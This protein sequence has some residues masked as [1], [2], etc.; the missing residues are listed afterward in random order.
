MDHRFRYAGILALALLVTG[1]FPAQADAVCGPGRHLA[2]HVFNCLRGDTS[3]QAYQ[4]SNPAA[5]VA[6]GLQFGAALLSVI[7]QLASQSQMTDNTGPVMKDQAH[8]GTM[9][10]ALN[11]KG[12]ALQE[13]GKFDE[14]RR[15]FLKASD[16][17]TLAGNLREAEINEKNAKIADAIY[18]LHR[19]YTLEKS[20]N[21]IKANIAYRLGIDSARSSGNGGLASQLVKSNNKLIDNH[22]NTKG[23][24]KSNE[25]T[26]FLVNG[27]YSCY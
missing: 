27:K 2:E 21:A 7:G 25:E 12:L 15:A 9:S 11:R 23:L 13:Q 24:I 16:E 4:R 8:H 19:G 5:G 20:G 14:A 18:W 17:A 22:R 3:H 26:C 6:A 10:R 1:P